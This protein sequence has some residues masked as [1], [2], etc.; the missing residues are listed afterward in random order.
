MVRQQDMHLVQK[1][2]SL[3][4]VQCAV[5]QKLLLFLAIDTCSLSPFTGMKIIT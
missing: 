2:E 1:D 5:P 4:T 3:I